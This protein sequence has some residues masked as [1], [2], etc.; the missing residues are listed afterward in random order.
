MLDKDNNSIT[1]AQSIVFHNINIISPNQTLKYFN[2]LFN[3]IIFIINWSI[4][5]R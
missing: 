4:A 3:E 2:C 1:F 5:Y